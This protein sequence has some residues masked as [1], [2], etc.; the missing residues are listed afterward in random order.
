M[1]QKRLRGVMALL[2]RQRQPARSPHI[3]ASEPG[4][5]VHIH[6]RKIILRV[7]I[8]E[9]GRRVLEH[10]QRALGIGFDLAVG[11]AVEAI[12]AD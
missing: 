12:D 7:R 6:A 9:I 4:G 10:L 8:A 1:A 2:G 5:A 11:N 3:V